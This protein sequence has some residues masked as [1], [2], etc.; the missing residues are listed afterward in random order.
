MAPRSGSLRQGARLARS[1]ARVA[2]ETVRLGAISAALPGATATTL[3]HRLPILAG[4]SSA[5]A[6]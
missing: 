5:S 3:A 4:F 2:H 1:G 6:L